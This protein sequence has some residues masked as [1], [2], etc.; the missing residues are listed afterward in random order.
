M[1]LCILGRQPKLGLAELE[2]LYG[3]DA[4]SPIADQ[5]V[6]VD[7][8]L[9][10]VLSRPL[11][12]TMK[13]ANVLK[14]VE[15]T[16]WQRAGQKAVTLLEK[17][18]PSSGKITLGLS[19]YG[20][21]AS[22]RE[23]QKTG[24]VIKQR[25]KNRE[26]SIRII[27]QDE[28]VLNTAQV[29]HNKLG[30]NELK[31]ELI[32]VATDKGQTVVAETKHVQDI[33]AYTFRDR[34]RP[35]RDAFVG[36]LPPKLAQIMINLGAGANFAGSFSN[37]DSP[38]PRGAAERTFVSAAG[39]REETGPAKLTTAP[40]VLDPFCGTGVVL[41]EAAL[42]GYAVY[43]T[44]LSERMVRYSRDNLNWLED[45]HHTTFDWYLH[46]A[47]A[48]NAHWQQPINAVVCETYLGQPFSTEPNPEK[49]ESVRHECNKIFKEFM[50]NLAGQI[51]P[52]TPLCVAVPAWHTKKGII[53]LPALDDLLKIGYNRIDFTCASHAELIYHREDQ[54]VGR[55]LLVL[56]RS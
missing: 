46:Q 11:G 9:K 10:V 1:V 2:R 29:L 47:D 16:N 44:D 34:S 49:L 33:D 28:P 17:S 3:S 24:I 13:I 53:R 22:A 55:E 32:F 30:T 27:P 14:V 7:V 15:T 38:S 25:L 23:V 21:A 35:R 42:M 31:K 8:P 5:A 52:G 12:G 4:L 18:L 37:E 51:E 43:G 45:T 40:R 50:Q 39:L 20:F 36:M 41:Q 54:I 26:G 6:L 19:A 48:Q 56:T